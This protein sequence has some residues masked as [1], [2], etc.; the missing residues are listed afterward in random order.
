MSNSWTQPDPCPFCGNNTTIVCDNTGTRL[1]Y[2]GHFNPDTYP[3]F[4]PFA[5]RCNTCFARGPKANTPADAIF[6]F[7]QTEQKGYS[8]HER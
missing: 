8:Q 1:P 6:A 5:V 2:W 7:N 4:R 3:L